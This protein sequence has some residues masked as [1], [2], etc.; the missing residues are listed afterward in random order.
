MSFIDKLKK[1]VKSIVDGIT[2]HSAEEKIKDIVNDANKEIKPRIEP[3]HKPLIEEFSPPT[4][5]KTKKASG[6]F[7]PLLNLRVLLNDKLHDEIKDNM[8]DGSFISSEVLNYRTGRFARSAKVT[9]LTQSRDE[10]VKV[11]Y[12]YMRYPYDT[13]L[14]PSGRQSSHGRSPER[15]VSTSIRNIAKQYLKTSERVVTILV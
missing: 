8:G 10:V 5:V 14:P 6:R 15:I 9:H 1:F 12:T 3:N 7:T 11:Y 4:E 13:F 2:H